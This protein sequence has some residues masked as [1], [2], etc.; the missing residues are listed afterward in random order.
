MVHAA[1]QMVR[2]AHDLVTALALDMRNESDTTAVMLEFGT[3]E[4]PSRP[5]AGTSV[6]L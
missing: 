4:A 3:I 5:A 2:I 1:E 6:W